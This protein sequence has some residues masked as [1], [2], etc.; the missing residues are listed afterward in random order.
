M[1]LLGAVLIILSSAL[2]FTNILID[3]K[4]P[5]HILEFMQ[6][7][8]HSRWTF[9]L[10]LNLFLLVVGCLMDVFSAILVVVPLILPIAH[11]FDVNPVHL[12][13]IFLTNLEIGYI[14]PPVGMNLFLSSLRFGHRVLD[15]CRASFPFLLLLLAALGLIT[16]VPWL[17]TALLPA[18]H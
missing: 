9:L 12:G 2:G 4:V 14:T 16:Y 5:Q 13:I 1:V 7:H 8:I 11:K 10:I 6:V 3:L 17:S 15:V 18:A